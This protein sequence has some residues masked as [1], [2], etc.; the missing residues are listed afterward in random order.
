MEQTDLKPWEFDESSMQEILLYTDG[1]RL[2]DGINKSGLRR[3]WLTLFNSNV[4]KKSDQIP[5]NDL[6]DYWPLYID[7]EV[8]YKIAAAMKVEAESEADTLRQQ[9]RR[10]IDNVNKEDA[11]RRDEGST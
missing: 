1:Y 5:A 11:R 2:K 7:P 10:L 4:S 6:H 3:I 9:Y 8:N